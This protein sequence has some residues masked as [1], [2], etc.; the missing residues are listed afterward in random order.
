[1]KRSAYEERLKNL[2][3]FRSLVYDSAI[4][5]APSETSCS[6]ESLDRENI[7]TVYRKVARIFGNNSNLRLT[8]SSAV[9]QTDIATFADPLVISRGDRTHIVEIVPVFRAFLNFAFCFGPTEPVQAAKTFSFRSFLGNPRIVDI[10]SIHD[11]LFRFGKYYDHLFGTVNLFHNLIMIPYT[12]VRDIDHG[13][14]FLNGYEIFE[15]MEDLLVRFGSWVRGIPETLS[16][17]DFIMQGGRALT[18][19]VNKT[20]LSSLAKKHHKSQTVKPF[21][22]KKPVDYQVVS[23][24]STPNARFCLTEILWFFKKKDKKCVIKGCPFSHDVKS[25]TKA[26]LEFTLNKLNNVT[27]RAEIM[28]LV[29]GRN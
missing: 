20:I 21:V 9:S 29:K 14:G 12:Q 5:V 4:I 23:V 27:L 16:V 17:T 18:L 28:E 26:Q 19:D 1:M 7:T 10:K 8:A 2:V 6:I 3:V 13:L 22:P 11:A 25:A 24:N 15:I